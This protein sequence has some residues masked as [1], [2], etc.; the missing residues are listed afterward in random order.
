V[1]NILVFGFYNHQNLGDDLF[2]EAYKLLFP[3]YNFIFVN[4]IA[5]EDLQKVDIVFIGGGSLLGEPLKITDIK[6]LNLLRHKKIFYIGVG[7]ETNIHKDHLELMVLAKLIALRSDANLDK[8]KDINPHTI[9]IPDLVY[10]LTPTLAKSKIKKSVLVIPNIAVVPTWNDPHWKHAAWDYF[11]T[12]MAQLLDFLVKEE[13]YTVNFLPLCT[14]IKLND[15]WAANEI[16]SRMQYRNT[17]FLLGKKNT[18]SSVTQ[19]ISQYEIVITQR[20]HG[21]ILSEMSQAPSLNIFHHD[22]LKNHPG[23][24]LSYYGL[25]KD[26]LSEQFNLIRNTKVSNILPINRDMFISL[27]RTVDSALRHH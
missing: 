27:Q 17:Q 10:S 14:D 6:V 1:K 11:K 22:K 5:L 4:Q 3:T 24:S 16:I 12:E 26:K 2:I 7:A 21:I 18:L 25:S 13:G 20:Y 9:V 15:I 19:L 8:I 23:N